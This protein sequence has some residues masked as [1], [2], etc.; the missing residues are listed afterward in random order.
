MG[1]HGDENRFGGGNAAAMDLIR[2]SLITKLYVYN[3][4]AR[5]TI[6]QADLRC[7]QFLLPCSRLPGGESARR[8]FVV[9]PA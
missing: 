7:G 9:G 3:T 8:D 2:L 5:E 4:P 1:L 6:I